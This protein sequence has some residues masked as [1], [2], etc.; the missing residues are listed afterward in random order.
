[1][2][3]SVSALQSKHDPFRAVLRGV[4]AGKNDRLAGKLILSQVVTFA[5]PHIHTAGIVS[6]RPLDPG[7]LTDPLYS[8][9]P[10]VYNK[11][12]GC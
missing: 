10:T 2:V 9:A 8:I 11:T 1:M 5:A 12:T 6:R 7:S 4:S 3:E